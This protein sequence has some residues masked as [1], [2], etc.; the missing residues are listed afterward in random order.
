[1]RGLG[2][3]LWETCLEEMEIAAFHGFLPQGNGPVVGRS[4]RAASKTPYSFTAVFASTLIIGVI[5]GISQCIWGGL[6]W[7]TIWI[8]FDYLMELPGPDSQGGKD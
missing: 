3:S 8:L 2:L 1:M 4:G 5:S 7:G 6:I